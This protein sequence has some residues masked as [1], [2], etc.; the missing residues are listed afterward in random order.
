[1]RTRRYGAVTIALVA[2]GVATVLAQGPPTPQAPPSSKGVVLKGKA[3]VSEELLRVRL[4]KPAA[5][6]L[7]NGLHLL[8]LEDRRVPRVTMQLLVPGAGGY[9]DP[10]ELA[11]VATVTA[12]LMREGTATRSSAQLSEQL[13]AMAASVTVGAGMSSTEATVFGSSLTE[14]VDKMFDIFADVLLHPSFPEDELGRYKQRTRAMLT[15]QRSSPGFL[16]AEMFARV[17]YGAHPASRISLTADT[18]DRMTTAALRDFHQTRFVPDHAGLAIAGDISLGEARR[19][20][21]AKMA[22]WKKSGTAKGAVA[23]PPEQG[24][25]RITFIARPNSVQT[26]LIV[27]TQAIR[28]LDPDYDVL[29]VMNKVIG[30]GPTGRLFITLREDKGYT[31]GAYS[32]LNAGEWR[33]AWQ[34]STE[35][36]TDVTEAALRDLLAEVARMRD[37][38]VPDKEFRDQKRAM[39]GS[40]AL[41]LENPQQVLSYYI[42]SWR[43]G[44]PPDYWDKYPDRMAAVT[45]AQVR[46]AAKKYLDPSRLHVIAVGEPAKVADVLRKFGTL[47]TYD[48]EGKRMTSS[49]NP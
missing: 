24:A 9:Y 20:V 41:S 21:E 19:L 18:L 33:G 44:L 40:F 3:P 45:Q 5:V 11:G 38:S 28:R 17:M 1:M 12:A 10:A 8:V 36:R 29:Q 49:S 16:G 25:P 14:H 7:A 43:Y 13:E 30:G 46:A 47:E 32:G 34:A 37:E 27:G 23:D 26:N 15:Q 39:I 4:P 42:T 31:Y 6:T 2:A 22:S 35:V 48:T